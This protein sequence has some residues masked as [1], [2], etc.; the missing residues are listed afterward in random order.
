VMQKPANSSSY[1]MREHRQ[2]EAP[3][4]F[5]QLTHFENTSNG[6]RHDLV[7]RPGPD[8]IDVI[9]WQLNAAGDVV[10]YS[11][12]DY[13]R[14]IVNTQPRRM[15]ANI[16]GKVWSGHM[17][18]PLAAAP[19]G[20]WRSAV[21][22]VLL[23]RAGFPADSIGNVE[24]AL[25]Y[26]T[27][28]ASLNERVQ[29]VCAEIKGALEPDRPLTTKY[30]GFSHDGSI[31]SHEALRLLPAIQVGMLA[32]ARLELNLYNLLRRLGKPVGKW[33]G[34][35]FQ[36]SECRIDAP[37][38]IETA[39]ADARKYRVF[40]EVSQG[41][42]W[43]DIVRSEFHERELR[44][45][46]ERV[47]ARRELEFVIPNPAC[48]SDASTNSVSIVPIVKDSTTGK[49]YLGLRKISASHSQFPAIQNRE[50]HSGLASIVTFRL[51]SAI[52]H[53]QTV[54]AWIAEQTGLPENAVRK[55]GEGYFPSLGVLPDRMFP[56]VATQLSSYWQ[57]QCDFYA[58]DDVFAHVEELRDA[59][60]M[61]AV[62]RLTHALQEW[63][64]A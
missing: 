44:D 24:P 53:T 28:P 10:I 6:T 21:D 41:S 26:Y 7:Q 58:L 38:R 32:E 20:D 47:L 37:A 11:K 62:F 27:A 59:N 57:D 55:L 63:P 12:C 9:P 13:P 48:A 16:D 39:F 4:S 14:P 46:R 1:F 19:T 64:Q 3:P 49:N 33:I 30:S 23:Q 52:V 8:V 40:R 54:P 61:I 56:Y 2:A 25:S 43:I 50:G 15:T 45:N 34:G 22:E 36:P 29:S 18:E 17:I 5:L 42:D 60:T 31:R 35:A 51:P